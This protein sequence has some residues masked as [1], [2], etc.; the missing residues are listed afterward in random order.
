MIHFMPDTEAAF[1]AAVA[2][3]PEDPEIAVDDFI[4]VDPAHDDLMQHHEINGRQLI[5]IRII[6][7][8]IM[9]IFI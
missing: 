2:L 5:V 6:G 9:A 3:S 8:R 1:L 7:Q 4:L